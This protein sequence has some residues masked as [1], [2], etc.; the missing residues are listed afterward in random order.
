M[1]LTPSN[2]L[3]ATVPAGTARLADV[4][5]PDVAMTGVV[6]IAPTNRVR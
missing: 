3:I 5:T 6:I 4:R 2:D 1:I